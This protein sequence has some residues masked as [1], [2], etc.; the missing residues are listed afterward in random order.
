[1]A[2]VTL[3]VSGCARYDSGYDAMGAMLGMDVQ[4]SEEKELE[5]CYQSGY[6]G[7][8]VNEDGFLQRY[9]EYKASGKLPYA[10][11]YYVTREECDVE[12]VKGLETRYDELKPYVEYR[13]CRIER[14]KQAALER[15]KLL[16][17]EAES[18]RSAK[19][20][21]F[22]ISFKDSEEKIEALFGDV[23]GYCS[24]NTSRYAD[25]SVT[26]Q[27]ACYSDELYK[28]HYYYF[29]NGKMTS[30]QD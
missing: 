9:D 5:A 28:P 29:T 2:W 26:T 14:E 30:I 10:T 17:Q 24:R 15:Q 20:A 1:M 23:G 11:V 3:L 6:Q 18:R 4:S 25:G 13:N 16:E 27:L 19:L 12:I 8:H 7:L 21:I 22:G